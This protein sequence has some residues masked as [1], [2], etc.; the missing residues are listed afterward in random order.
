MRFVYF[1]KA[2]KIEI[3][4]KIC[5]IHYPSLA[6]NVEVHLNKSVETISQTFRSQSRL[7]ITHKQSAFCGT[8]G[9]W[10]QAFVKL[11]VAGFRL[12]FVSS[13]Q[14]NECRKS[15]IW[16]SL[17]ENYWVFF[18]LFIFLLFLTFFKRT[19]LCNFQER[20]MFLYYIGFLKF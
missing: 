5:G 20:K 8:A 10:R 12:Y 16:N 11:C 1:L 15:E 2:Y 17:A 9:P 19:T 7:Y 3:K 13:P 6:S 14:T 4:F 18:H